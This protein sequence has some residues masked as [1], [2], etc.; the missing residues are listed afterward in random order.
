[1]L[2]TWE[3]VLIILLI[4]APEVTLAVKLGNRGRQDAPPKDG[5]D[6]QK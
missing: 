6:A 1:M 4:L 3:L 5:R 2:D